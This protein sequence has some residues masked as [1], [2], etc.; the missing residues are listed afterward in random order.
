MNELPFLLAAGAMLCA[1]FAVSYASQSFRLP[2]VLSFILL[3]AAAHFW[4]FQNHLVHLA[5]EIGIVL[6]FFVLGLEFPLARMRDI[7]R[8]IW[9]AGLLDVIFNLGGTIGI[10]WAFGLDFFTAFTI[11]SIAYAT[12][13]SMSA[14]MLDE[15]KRLA[16]PETEFI[17]ALLIFEDLVAP[18]LVSVLAGTQ[19]GDAITAG[20]LGLLLAK[21]ILLTAS[22]MFLGLY[23]FRK[24]SVFVERNIDTDFMPLF[25]VG[26]ALGYAGFAVWLGLSEILGAFLAG[27]MLSETGRSAELE[28]LALPIR[29]LCLPFFFFW[30][31]TSIRFDEGVS[32]IGILAALIVWAVT[33]KV[34]AVY[35]GATRYG[36]SPKVACRAACSM[37]QRGEFSAII[38]SLAPPAWRVFSGIY[39]LTTAGI[40]MLLFDKAP[41]LAKR[42][43]AK[44]AAPDGS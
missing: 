29:D 43:V 40:G 7:S 16:S 17:L 20:S 4:F 21:L 9:P 2:S 24:I 13:S 35:A 28:H 30:F 23:G 37:V 33:G 10:G 38:A 34:I 44:A 26:I 39:I 25:S 14:K 27:M 36:L 1:F 22:A 6:M 15:K 42:F 41:I 12:S 8:K 32:N 31:G 19:G 18:V 5:S 11:G 3:G